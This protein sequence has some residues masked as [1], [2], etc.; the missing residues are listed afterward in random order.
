MYMGNII[1]NRL[2]Y[3]TSNMILGFG[4]TED[5]PQGFGVEFTGGFDRGEFKNRFYGGMQFW[6]ASWFDRFGYFLFTT[7]VASYMYRRKAE[8]GLLG[9]R[10]TYFTPLIDLG[11]FKFR[12]FLYANY[13]KGFNRINDLTIDIQ[14]N[15]GIRGLTDPGLVG[16]ERLVFTLESRC[17][18][19]WTLLGFRF[20]F[21]SFA[22]IGFVGDG[23][24]LLFK[25]NLSSALGLGCQIRNEGLVLQTINLRVAYY[26]RVPQG[27]SPFGFAISLSEPLF[28]T[29]PGLGKPRIFI[30][31]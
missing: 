13:L 16:T 19:P 29:Q 17:F 14:D 21:L 4:R 1:V 25:K 7:R 27:I 24:N 20:S 11:H 12:H 3:L 31:E 26:P 8:D 6:L 9:F 2:E 5:I 22:D 23:H 30:F 10:L 18:A 28:F 15:N